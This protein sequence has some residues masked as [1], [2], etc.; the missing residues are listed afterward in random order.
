MSKVITFS[1]YFPSYHSKG[2]QPTGFV[3]KIIWGLHVIGLGKDLH[4][5]KFKVP[6]EFV[7]S[8][9][10]EGHEAPKFHT[11]RAGHRFKEGD[12]FSPRVWSG[13]P[14]NSKQIQFAPDI[15]VTKTW[16]FKLLDD[17]CIYINGGLY[18]YPNSDFALKPLA[19]NDGLDWVDLLNWFNKPFEGQIICWN[20]KIEY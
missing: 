3:E 4:E 10:L 13:K 17:G 1:R 2:G 9:K 15:E 14:Y 19:E 16:D 18:A 6:I 5:W 8:F 7:H 20:D 11:I 12:W